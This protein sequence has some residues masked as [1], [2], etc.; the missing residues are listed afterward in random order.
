MME[1]VLKVREDNAIIII[2]DGLN[3]VI[4]RR[5]CFWRQDMFF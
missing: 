4:N 1:T 3:S 5:I 2:I